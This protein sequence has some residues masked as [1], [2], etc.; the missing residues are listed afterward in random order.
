MSKKTYKIKK[1]RE[2]GRIIKRIRLYRYGE[3]FFILKFPDHDY[4]AERAAIKAADMCI[5]HNNLDYE[6]QRMKKV[7]K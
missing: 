4:E 5:I 6:T 7:C 1:I 3:E 2:N